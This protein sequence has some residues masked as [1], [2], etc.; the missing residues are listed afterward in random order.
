MLP[1]IYIFIIHPRDSDSDPTQPSPDTP[2]F[3]MTT[4]HFSIYPF[5]H[6]KEWGKNGEPRFQN[7]SILSLYFLSFSTIPIY[8]F[9]HIKEWG[10][11][12]SLASKIIPSSPSSSFPSLLSLSPLY[13]YPPFPF[14]L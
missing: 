12:G 4:T 1:Y 7:Y 9:I 8:P 6:I 13:L 11:T 5:I 2:V 10:K 3:M 14:L